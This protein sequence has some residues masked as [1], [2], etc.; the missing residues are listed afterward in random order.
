MTILL[1][2]CSYS[3][4]FQIEGGLLLSDTGKWKKYGQSVWHARETQ[5]DPK[6]YDSTMKQNK[7]WIKVW[8]EKFDEAFDVKMEKGGYKY[9][10]FYQGKE[11]CVRCT[12]IPTCFQLHCNKLGLQGAHVYNQTCMTDHNP[13]ICFIAPSCSEH[14]PAPPR[15]E[16]DE[17]GTPSE[18]HY[19]KPSKHWL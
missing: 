1:Y 14:N 6:I 10:L 12:E 3:Y 15:N 17:G 5:H 19:P 4:S 9:D 11:P 13:N 2:I 16:Y 7:S 18:E 8:K